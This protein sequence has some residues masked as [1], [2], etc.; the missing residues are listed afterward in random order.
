MITFSISN[1]E[2]L[3]R[4]LATLV[5]FK[6]EF[7]KTAS[8]DSKD[9]NRD[10]KNIESKDSK[11]PHH[12]LDARGKVCPFPLVDAKEAIK[13][14]KS[15]EVLEILFDCTQATE[16]IPLWAAENNHE[17]T[18]FETLGDA[19]WRIVLVRA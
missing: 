18:I 11:K 8:L 14:V 13:H 3:D 7:V 5:G 2:I 12:T 15:G 17:I 6:G 16:T 4:V 19:E 10:A 1:N 9:F